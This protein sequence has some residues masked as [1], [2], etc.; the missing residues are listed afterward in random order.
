MKVFVWVFCFFFFFYI[1]QPLNDTVEDLNT[2]I[3]S[4]EYTKAVYEMNIGGDEDQMLEFEK[5]VSKQEV[6][7]FNP[8]MN[9]SMV[10]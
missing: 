3:L 5:H 7:F 10:Y 2:K 9:I 1:Y 8:E 6:S 4:C